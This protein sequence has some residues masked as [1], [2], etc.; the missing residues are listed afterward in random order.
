MSTVLIPVK[1]KVGSGLILVKVKSRV[2]PIATCPLQWF[3]LRVHL[4]APSA[5]C[6]S[7]GYELICDARCASVFPVQLRHLEA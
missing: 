4:T 3:L 1:S 5:S 2:V 7:V 6:L